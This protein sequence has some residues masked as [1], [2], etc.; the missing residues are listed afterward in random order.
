MAETYPTTLPLPDD[1]GYGN[2]QSYGTIRTNLPGPI[3]EQE[4][5]YN[6]AR[7]LITATFSMD[8]ATYATWLAW[9][10]AN[11]Y[12]W[13]YMPVVSP[14]TPVD[15]SS[16]ALVRATDAPTMSLAGY[17][18]QRASLSLEMIPGAL[19]DPL[20]PPRVYNNFIDAGSPASLSPDIIDAGNAAT[21]SPDIF[22]ASLYDYGH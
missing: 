19:D 21:P 2:V 13:F 7:V 3:K 17:N 6:S 1:T 4:T 9:I 20:A 11:A 5:T 12:E 15:I 22:T 16:T 10:K 14:R 18:W 8:D